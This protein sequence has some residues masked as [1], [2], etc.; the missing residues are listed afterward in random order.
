GEN[1]TISEY[2]IDAVLKAENCLLVAVSDRI[3]EYGPSG[4]IVFRATGDTLIIES[5]ALSC[6]IL[7]KQVEYAI[8]SALGRIASERRC[9]R[10]EFNYLKTPR[11]QLMPAFLQQFAERGLET[12]YVV[13]V[14]NLEAQIY[15]VAVNPGAWTVTD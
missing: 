3:S 6:T 14:Q 10:I 11:N 5:F 9:A 7:G 1:P 15:K 4:L 13:S 8:L 2:E 12:A